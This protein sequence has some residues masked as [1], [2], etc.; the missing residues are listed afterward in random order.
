[1]PAP[2]K[3]VLENLY[4]VSEAAIRLGLRDLE[5]PSKKG[6]KWLRDGVN[7]DGFPCH[8]M[9]GQL[10]FSDTDL[11]VI[12]ERHRNK[13]EARGRYTR[14]THRKPAANVP[15]VADETEFRRWTPKEVVE[16]QLLPYRTVR[17]LRE[18]CYRHEV[19]HHKDGG[20]ITFTAEDI[21]LENARTAV[22]PQSVPAQRKTRAA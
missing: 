2:T 3:P 19:H 16:K 21:R 18:K 5:D 15:P 6:E 7:R 17:S 20:R 8:R 22:T 13:A 4:S 9:A 10:M 12:A 14:R 1:M 11:A